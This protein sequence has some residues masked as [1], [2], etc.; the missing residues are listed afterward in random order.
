MFAR[1]LA[2]TPLGAKTLHLKPPGPYLLTSVHL[3]LLIRM[4]PGYHPREHPHRCMALRGHPHTSTDRM[5]GTIGTG[6]ED[7][8]WAGEVGR[9]NLALGTLP[10]VREQHPKQ[11]RELEPV[12]NCH[13]HKK[14]RHDQGWDTQRQIHFGEIGFPHSQL[15]LQP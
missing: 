9:P 6:V 3:A 7:L 13:L 8:T 12:T 5:S 14:L 2:S 11:G 4:T 10:M 15:Q 1:Q